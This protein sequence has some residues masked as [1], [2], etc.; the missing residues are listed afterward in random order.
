MFFV[1]LGREG[2]ENDYLAYMG[3]L[4]S[5]LNEVSDKR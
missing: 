5:R 3:Q 1:L 4:W 2:W